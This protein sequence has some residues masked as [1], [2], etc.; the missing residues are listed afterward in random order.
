MIEQAP[1]RR[2]QH[3]QSLSQSRFLRLPLLSA[4]DR[5]GHN[6]HAGVATNMCRYLSNLRCQLSGR[7]QYQNVRAVVPAD[8]RLEAV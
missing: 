7:S 8:L 1:G 4:A 6:V 3:V 2:N 5:P